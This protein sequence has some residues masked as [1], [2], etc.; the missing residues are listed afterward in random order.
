MDAMAYSTARKHLA[1]TME[2]ICDDHE[3]IIITRKNARSVVMI[4]LE[5]YNSIE[6]TGYLLRNPKNAARLRTSILQYK[7]GK[8]IKGKLIQE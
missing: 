8:T 5:D 4:S 7:K 6:E 1:K 3:A 2:R